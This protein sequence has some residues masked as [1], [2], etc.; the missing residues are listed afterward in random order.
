MHCIQ[1][2]GGSTALLQR[3]LR[4]GYGPAA[5]RSIPEIEGS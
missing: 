5:Q 1:P 2:Q 4:I 3:R